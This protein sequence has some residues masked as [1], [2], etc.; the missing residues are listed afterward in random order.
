MNYL[1]LIIIG[2]L[3]VW[4]GYYFARQKCG[5]VTPEQSKKKAE[6]KKRVLDFLHE[7]EKV[8]NN[9]IEKLLG[10]SDATAERYLNELEKEERISQHGTI[11]QNVFYTLR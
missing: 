10:V 3:G 7:N 9:D 5:S 11:G 2:V 1:V 8:K 6:N 4:L